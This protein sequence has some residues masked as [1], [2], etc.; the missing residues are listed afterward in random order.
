M[1]AYAPPIADLVFLLEHVV[2]WREHAGASGVTAADLESVIAQAGKLACELFA[3]LN[4]P[5]DRSPSSYVNGSVATPDGW[6][7]AYRAWTAAGWNGISLPQ[8]FGGS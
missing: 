5:A 1:T 7:S 2:C 8:D 6:K 4:Q 3:P